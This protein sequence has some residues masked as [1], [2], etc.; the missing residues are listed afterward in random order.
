MSLVE[1]FEQ[2][3]ATQFIFLWCA[4]CY[5]FGW[6]CIL[7]HLITQKNGHR[8]LSFK[9]TLAILLFAPISVPYVI[10]FT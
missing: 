9:R 4:W 2:S 6:T 7:G 8:S 3:W 10:W 1:W 5:I